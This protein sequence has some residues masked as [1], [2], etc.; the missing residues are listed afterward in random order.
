ME[1]RITMEEA[2]GR[3]PGP[4][5]ERFV[6]MLERGTL[7][8]ELYAPRGNDPQE[9]HEQDEVYVVMLGS[10]EFSNGGVR[11][12]FRAGDVLFVPAGVEHRFESFTDDLTVWVI[13]YGPRGGEQVA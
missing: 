13:F 8:V 11:H 3:L 6:T 4:N 1:Y 10:G 9:P 7:Q 5:G 2:L 12:P